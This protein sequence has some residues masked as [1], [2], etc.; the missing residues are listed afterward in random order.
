MTMAQGG[1]PPNLPA[2]KNLLLNKE[3]Q[4][5]YNAKFEKQKSKEKLNSMK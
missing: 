3:Y 5:N 1:Y 4:N 2:Q